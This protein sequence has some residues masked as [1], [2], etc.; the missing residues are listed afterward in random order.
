MRGR[1]L[2]PIAAAVAW[3]CAGCAQQG[4]VVTTGSSSTTS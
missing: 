1:G 4:K 2:I 3:L